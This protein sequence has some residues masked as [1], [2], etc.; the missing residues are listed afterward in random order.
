MLRTILTATLLG[1][2]L[3]ASPVLA[4]HN[5]PFKGK[6]FKVNLMTAYEPCTAPDTVTDDGVSACSTLQRSDPLCGFGGGQGKVQLKS[7]TVGNIAFRIKLNGVDDPC[8]GETINF[9]LS[10]RKT[11][12]HCAGA[13]CTTVDVIDYPLGACFVTRNVCKAS[14]ALFLPGGAQLGQIEILDVH[15]ERLGNRVFTPG[16]I[17]RKP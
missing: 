13:S 3:A 15:A 5:Q 2:G 4:F 1:V 14:G 16:L 6:N 11:G 10:F 12:H 9:F 8:D 7:L 17:T